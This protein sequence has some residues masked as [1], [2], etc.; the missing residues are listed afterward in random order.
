MAPIKIK[1]ESNATILL[2]K[3]VPLTIRYRLRH[4]RAIIRL[5]VCWGVH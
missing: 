5:Y 2:H 3:S 4:W 1:L